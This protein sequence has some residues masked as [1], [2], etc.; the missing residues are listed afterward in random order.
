MMD[1]SD[2]NVKIKNVICLVEKDNVSMELVNALMDGRVLHVTYHHV[3]MNAV[4]MD[5]VLKGDVYAI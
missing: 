1:T 4:I 5:N 3:L 2:L